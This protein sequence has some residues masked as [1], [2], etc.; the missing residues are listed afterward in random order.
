MANTIFL[1][2]T[3][4][5]IQKNL[6]GSIDDTVDTI[7]LNNTTNMTAPGY[8]V[9]NRKNSAGTATPNDREVVSYTAISGSDLTG[10]T[11]GAD[12]ST[13]REHGDN[14]IVEA[15][16]TIGMWNNLA[17]IVSTGFTSDGYLKAIASP[18]SIADMHSA[19][20]RITTHLTVSGASVSGANMGLYPVFKLT[21]SFSGATTAVGG[22]LSV[23]RPTTLRWASAVLNAAAPVS[24]AS[25]W[26]DVNK[27]FTSIFDEGTRLMV[28]AGGTYVST[29]SIA[30]KNL[31][32][33]N[34][35][36]PD[37]DAF[38]DA[39]GFAQDITV[40]LGGY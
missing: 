30:T 36:T 26:I 23:P 32:T 19:T 13:A 40:Q 33:G 21:G 10:C 7:T 29:A 6:S 27:N 28:P 2:P 35:L 15:I 8:V 25:L 39:D 22:A 9:I 4:N 12:G 14:S 16:L 1:A 20:N 3:A 17:T 18:V 11:R 24:T 31:D 37:I 38:G 5:Y 34:T